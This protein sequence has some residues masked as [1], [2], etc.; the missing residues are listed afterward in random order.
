MRIIGL[1]FDGGSFVSG[2]ITGAVIAGEPAWLLIFAGLA[3]LDWYAPWLPFARLTY[4]TGEGWR[5]QWG[6]QG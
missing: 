2:I 4:K 3:L 6:R 1:N 5:F